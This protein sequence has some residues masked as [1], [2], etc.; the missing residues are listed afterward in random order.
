MAKELDKEEK[1]ILSGKNKK[2]T[3]LDSLRT[4]VMLRV[5][6]KSVQHWLGLDVIRGL[7]LRGKR[8]NRRGSE[9]KKSGQIDGM[10]ARWEVDWGGLRVKRMTDW[11]PGLEDEGVRQM[12]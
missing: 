3:D 7:K 11:L 6:L 12:R 4:D 1:L 9:R 8:K 10:H 5:V 2:N